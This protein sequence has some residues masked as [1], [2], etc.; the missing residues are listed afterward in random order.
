MNV[1]H[2]QI[3]TKYNNYEALICDIMYFFTS[4]SIKCVDYRVDVTEVIYPHRASTTNYSV[5]WIRTKFGNRA[6]SVAALSYGTVSLQQFVKQ[7]A[8][9]PIRL[10]AELICSLRFNERLSVVMYFKT[11][12]MHSRS[13]AE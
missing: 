1:I 6:F 10:S 8:C 13:G 11:F 12:V 7:T 9:T 2:K 5:P 3:F 4:Y